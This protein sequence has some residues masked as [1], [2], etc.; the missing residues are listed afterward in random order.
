MESADRRD[1]ILAELERILLSSS[2]RGTKRSQDFLRYV[3]T[4]ALDGRTEDLKE[5]CIGTDVFGRAAD[6]DTGDDSIVRVKASEV[7]KRLAQYYREPSAEGPVQIDLPPGSYAP[8]FRF[9]EEPAAVEPAISRRWPWLAAA[10]ALAA[11][12]GGF[13][14]RN[15]PAPAI[16]AFWRPVISNR[17]PV[18]LCVAHPAVYR[19][20]ERS[21]PP[22][23]AGTP[24]PDTV[25]GIDLTRDTEHYVGFGDALALAHLSA[26]FARTGKPTQLRLGNDVTFAD[27]RSSPAV[28]I[29]AFTNQWTIEITNDQRF[30]FERVAAGMVI[31]DRLTSHTWTTPPHGDYAVVTRIL[32]SKS[33]GIAITA[34]GLSHYGTQMAG[35]FLVSPGAIEEAL[36]TAP[37]DWEWRNLQLVLYAEVIGRTPGPPRAVASYYW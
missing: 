13:A 20:A 29:G 24:P 6:Y 15:R 9:R 36:R 35:E 21:R 12:A 14:L 3:V 2:F 28:L 26:F 19:L 23:E 27:F 16:D 30:S 31:R 17:Q 5:R 32:N 37:P 4:T 1:A 7:R 18:L 33:G 22:F 10:A 34:A 11:A 8:E 25:P